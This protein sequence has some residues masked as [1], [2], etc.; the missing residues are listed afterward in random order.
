MLVLS[1]C[2]PF[3]SE[4]SMDRRRRG[5]FGP[6][7]RVVILLLVF[8]VNERCGDGKICFVESWSLFKTQSSNCYDVVQ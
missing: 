1:L 2:Q 8:R 4:E 7:K 6:Q 3:D 5:S